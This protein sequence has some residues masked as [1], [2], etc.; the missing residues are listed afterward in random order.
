MLKGVALTSDI[1]RRAFLDRFIPR[2]MREGKVE[3]FTNL[4]QGGMSVLDYFIK[5]TM[6][7][8]YAPSLFLFNEIR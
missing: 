4:N 5:F 2:E 1:F 8:K 7:S 6:F 3:E